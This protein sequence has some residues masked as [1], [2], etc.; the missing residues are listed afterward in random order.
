MT[1]KTYRA[2]SPDGIAYTFKTTRQIA[3]A[4]FTK[5]PDGNYRPFFAKTADAARRAWGAKGVGL[6]R[7]TEI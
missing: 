2:V 3:Y 1:A 6:V 5:L 7:A 4:M